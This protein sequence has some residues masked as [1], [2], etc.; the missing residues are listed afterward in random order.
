MS[1]ENLKKSGQNTVNLTDNESL[2][3]FNKKKYAECG[4]LVH[5]V[6]EMNSG[7]T[8]YS[9]ATSYP[10][11]DTMFVS[12][13]D[14]YEAIYGDIGPKIPLVADNGYWKEKILEQIQERG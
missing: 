4:Y 8:L 2:W 10:K 7:L 1:L 11:D 13:F 3:H 6:V 12:V 9:M 5:N 14:K